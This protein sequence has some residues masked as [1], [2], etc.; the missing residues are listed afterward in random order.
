MRMIDLQKTAEGYTIR[1]GKFFRIFPLFTMGSLTIFPLIFLVWDWLDRR[2]LDPQ[3]IFLLSICVAGSLWISRVLLGFRLVIDK[4]GVH[5]YIAKRLKHTIPWKYV[6]SF[7]IDTIFVGGKGGYH[8][9]FYV[10]TDTKP[11]NQDNQLACMLNKQD[12]QA[13]R[14]E[15]VLAYCRAQLERVR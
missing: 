2:V 5:R 13:L 8:L 4:S 10:S 3:T 15:G 9:A 12:E 11:G 6:R 7:G 14:E 1:Y